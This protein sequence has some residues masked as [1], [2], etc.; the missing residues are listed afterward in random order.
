MDLILNLDKPQGITSQA[1]VTQVKRLF[2]VK[3][4][5]HAGTLD[6]MATGVLLVCM[7]EATKVVRFLVDMEK[8]YLATM[9]LGERT[10]TCDAEGRVTETVED[11]RVGE[12]RVREVLG[13]FTGVIRQTPPMYSAIKVAGKPLYKLARQGIVIEREE[14]EVTVSTLELGALALP[15]LTL[16]VVCS[17]GT[18]I[19]SLSDD[20]GQV[21]GTGAHL[22]A[23]R[24]VRI[25]NFLVRASAKL[26]E[27]PGK[28][29]AL[30]SIDSVLGHLREVVLNP[31]DFKLATHGGALKANNY[32]EFRGG[33]YLRLSSPG[34]SLFAVGYAQDERIKI[35]RILHLEKQT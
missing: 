5:G 6:P 7:G 31:S 4:A 3:K 21:L 26:D 10:D 13:E 1:A 30:H 14:R 16:R 8:E 22:T 18:Y 9:K 12:D 20:I 28:P 32:A 15:F 33:E 19:R 23:L 11:V 27:L 34:G 29:G 24:R 25:G 17:K 35:E 2:K